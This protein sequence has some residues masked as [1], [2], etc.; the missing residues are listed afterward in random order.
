MKD[1]KNSQYLENLSMN[2]T[3]G[4]SELLAIESF[5]IT[6]SW[7]KHTL[8]H[9]PPPPPAPFLEKKPLPLNPS[10]L[11]MTFTNSSHLKGC[12]KCRVTHLLKFSTL[13]IKLKYLLNTE[14]IFQGVKGSNKFRLQWLKLSKHSEVGGCVLALYTLWYICNHCT[15]TLIGTHL[16]Y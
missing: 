5:L 6:K 3:C 4:S 12:L 15:H 10:L 16:S 9:L 13:L 2:K 7:K 11:G 14:L 8:Y 1:L